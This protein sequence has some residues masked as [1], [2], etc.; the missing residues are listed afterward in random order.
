MGQFRKETSN[1]E[2]H[3][4][5]IWREYE[6][7]RRDAWNKAHEAGKRPIPPVAD[8]SAFREWVISYALPCGDYEEAHLVL[9]E[10]A[11]QRDWNAP[12]SLGVP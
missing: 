3:D 2:S 10:I 6:T 8:E 11:R 4:D 1:D 9:V 7:K 5:P 12:P